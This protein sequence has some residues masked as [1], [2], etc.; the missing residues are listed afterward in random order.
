MLK[1]LDIS[2]AVMMYLAEGLCLN[3]LLALKAENSLTCLVGTRIL[4]TTAAAATAIIISLGIRLEPD[5]R[6]GTL[7]VSK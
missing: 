3:A 6:T 2:F 5:S 7:F 1:N 4:A